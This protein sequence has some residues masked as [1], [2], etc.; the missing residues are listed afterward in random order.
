MDLELKSGKDPAYVS[1]L[2]AKVS[3]LIGP[4]KISRGI[5]QLAGHLLS[6]IKASPQI[7]CHQNEVWS[8]KNTCLFAQQ[9]ILASAAYN[10]S[11]SPMEGFDELRVKYELQ[12][13]KDEYTVPLVVSIGYPEDY[14]KFD[15]SNGV[16]DPST[17]AFPQKSRY[18]LSDIAFED[19][20]GKS[21]TFISK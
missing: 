17:I 21:P 5:R 13:P 7:H 9:V 2:P 15:D 6:P 1:S 4:G 16:Y 3:F 11:T 10:L 12:I 19:R 18:P 8:L 14:D 20:Y